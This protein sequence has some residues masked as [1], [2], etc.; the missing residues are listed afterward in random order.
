MKIRFANNSKG[1]AM[2]PIE[3]VIFGLVF[4]LCGVA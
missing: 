4:T 2:R 1:R 3:A